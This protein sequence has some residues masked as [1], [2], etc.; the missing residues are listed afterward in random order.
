MKLRPFSLFLTLCFTL[1][2]AAALH[3]D[4]RDQWPRFRG[5]DGAGY[6]P[7]EALPSSWTNKEWTWQATLPGTGHSSPIIWD[8]KVFL[9]S[10]NEEQK[11]RHLLCH[12][13]RTGKLLW[14]QDFQGISNVI[15]N[16][17]VPHQPV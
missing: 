17:T 15:T 6:A 14:Q 8:G 11:V 13:L 16:K 12:D 7:A 4:A 9:T 3:A 5:S 2:H 10:A 1:G